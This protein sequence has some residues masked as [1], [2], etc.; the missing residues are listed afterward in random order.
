M[1]R[2]SSQPST[3]LVLPSLRLSQNAKEFLAGATSGAAAAVFTAPL[4]LVKTV[5]QSGRGA[6]VID[7]YRQTLAVYGARGL[8]R[9][10]T[11]T[12]MGISPTWA[13]YFSTY[14]GLKRHLVEETSMSHCQIAVASA[15]GAGA[16]TQFTVNP[17]WVVKVRMQT[18]TTKSM[19]EVVT[20]MYRAEGL[21]SFRKGLTAS[22]LGTCHFAVQFPLYE[23]LAAEIL[24]VEDLDRQVGVMLASSLSKITASYTTYPLEV[25]RTR[26]QSQTLPHKYE[27]IMDCA[28]KIAREEGLRMFY[29]GFV[30]NMVK[31]VPA[32]VVTFSVYDYIT[33]N[34][35]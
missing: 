34:Y 2:T 26:L 9:G 13:I 22:M 28:S 19:V 31:A 30:V 15:I 32:T 29:R 11:P 6:G 3:L 12:L 1:E 7:V 10:L 23:I 4:D 14:D 8:F 35:I 5:L 21:R 27:G 17:I 18:S 33:R 25:I 16:L 20:Q 24:E